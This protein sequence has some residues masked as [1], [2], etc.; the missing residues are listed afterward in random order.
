MGKF[1]YFQRG[2]LN[3]SSWGGSNLGPE[4]SAFFTDGTGDSGTLH[5]TLG[6]NDDTSVIFKVKEDTITTSPG[7]TLTNN[8]GRDDLFLKIGLTLLDGS[9]NHIS[10]TSSR[11]TIQTTLNT[12]NGN[13]VKILSTRVIGTVDDSTNGET[14]GHAV[15]VT[16]NTTTSYKKALK[17]IKD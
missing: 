16:R 14:E 17:I 13:N 8:D 1:L 4:V 3:D 6:V 15:T 7:L 11:E 12:F 10:N 2:H 9:H 5:F